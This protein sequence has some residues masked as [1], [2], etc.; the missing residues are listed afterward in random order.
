MKKVIII[1]AALVMSITVSAQS[2][3]VGVRLNG[4]FGL[5]LELEYQHYLSGSN[6]LNLGVD[7]M[8][9]PKTSEFGLCVAGIYD[10]TF[11]KAGNF[12]FYAGPGL[13]CALVFSDPLVIMPGAVGNIGAQWNLGTHFAVS[14]DYRP[15]IYFPLALSNN[16]AGSSVHGNFTNVG[17]GFKYCF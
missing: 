10:F 11:A 14:L 5:G 4:M 1:L 7:C 2:K 17:L 9:S 12:D 6:F 8:F 15:G 16:G 13:F 3:S